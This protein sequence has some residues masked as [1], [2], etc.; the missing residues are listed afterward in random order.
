MQD[1]STNPAKR[2]L[3]EKM[4]R[5]EAN[6]LHSEL[7]RIA[8]RPSST[9]APLSY[10]QEQ[11]YLQAQLAARVAPH[12]RLFN[13]TV[14]IHRS[15]PLDVKALE[16]SLAEILRRHEAWRTTFELK[17]SIL[18]QSVNPTPD[19]CL[20]VVD[21]RH[22]PESKRERAALEFAEVGA[23]E[24]FDLAQ[25]PL[26][27]FQLVRLSEGE[28]RL[29]LTAHQ[30]VLD[31]VS[32]YHVF[33][34]ELVA[35]YEAFASGKPSPLEEPPVQYSD[36]AWW[37]RQTLENGALQEHLNY[38]RGMFVEGVPIL[39]VPTDYPRPPIQTFRGA[40]QPFAISR[41]VVN[42]AK[43]LSKAEGTSLFMTF[44][45]AFAIL[46]NHYTRQKEIVI[47]TVVPTRKH[48]EVQHLLGYFLNP[49]VLYFRLD[50]NP[51]FSEVLAQTRDI[52]LG[53]LSHEM[54]FH[55]LTNAIQPGTDLSRHPLFQV[56]FSLE[57]P[58]SGPVAGW[59][60]TPMDLQ[61]GGAK[62]DLYFVLDDRPNG[63]FGRAQYNPDLFE[64]ASLQRTIRTYQTLLEA[65]A[66]D[67]A[68]RL[69]ELPY[70]SFYD[71]SAFLPE[72]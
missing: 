2:A 14:T 3:F 41:E 36:Y 69:T 42:S 4:V 39:R 16:L 8:R 9:F 55:L 11:V 51:T 22:I 32:A 65:A 21:L 62:L 34:P 64:A 30:I 70:H 26:V 33:F 28:H 60:L 72:T 54:P 38:W 18:V 61:S 50:G 5:G 40:I 19:V 57:P 59:N 43:T 15:G 31:G 44:V 23:R 71:E 25:G 29:F 6:A 17:N 68:K 1:V 20:N 27:K 12:S 58:I 7:P 46:F 49:V 56:Q 45:A 66:A 53:A 37:Q 67:P 24:L 13:E 63:T 52:V 48:S 47:G 35:L 10:N